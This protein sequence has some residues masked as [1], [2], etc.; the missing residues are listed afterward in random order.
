MIQLRQFESYQLSDFHPQLNVI[1]GKNAQGKTSIL[2]ALSLISQLKSFRSHRL[3]ELI[4]SGKT[5]MSVSAELSKPTRS[6][7]LLAAEGN[8]KTI[9]LDEKRMSSASKYPLMGMSVS[10]VPDDLYLL[11]GGPD[12]RRQFFDDLALCV[13]PQNFQIYKNFQKALKQRNGLLK[14]I[15]EGLAS[16][17][18]LEIWT[19][20]YVSSAQAVYKLRQALLKK[21]EASLCLIYQSLFGVSEQ[22]GIRYEH[23]FERD[24][25]D[26]MD[27]YA[28]L[29]RRQDAEMAVGYTLVGPHRD[30]FKFFI[31]GL[32]VKA[33]A[34]QGQTRS[35]VIAL[36]I[37]QVELVR[38]Q[39]QVDPLLLLDDI[40]SELDEQRVQALVRYLANYSGQL[41]VTTAEAAKLKRLHEQFSSFKLIELSKPQNP[42]ISPLET[43]FK[44]I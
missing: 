9:R 30:D 36:K 3:D 14:Q 19:S 35:L 2:E 44:T 25:F 17:D 12:G 1:V 13:D 24:D 7:V 31:N 4:Q 41:F 5:Q 10:F 32:E 11:K 20:A 40:I 38:Q 8:R 22:I 18:Q 6:R 15:K 26:D 34:S 27:F 28:R 43:D 29:A 42:E 16:S 37:S 33:S 21:M 23:G 39:R